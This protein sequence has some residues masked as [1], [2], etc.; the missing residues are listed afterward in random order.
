METIVVV[1]SSRGKKVKILAVQFHNKLH[2]R[3]WQTIG[4]N[5]MNNLVVEA[6]EC[7]WHLTKVLG[8]LKTLLRPFSDNSHQN[9]QN[10]SKI[11]K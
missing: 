1:K 2:T 11:S 8:K 10:E 6:V 5:L 7:N 4:H 9:L 3:Y